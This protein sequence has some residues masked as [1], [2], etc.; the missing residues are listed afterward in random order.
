MEGQD[1]NPMMGAAPEPTPE[2]AQI[3]TPAPEPEPTPSMTFVSGTTTEPVPQDSFAEPATN[4]GASWQPAQATAPGIGSTNMTPGAS[5]PK[6]GNTGIIIAI[7]AAAVI[8][9]GLIVAIIVV[10][11]SNNGGGS[12]NNSSKTGSNSKTSEPEKDKN[13]QRDQRNIQREDDL[14]RMIT[15]VNDY[16]TNNN[17]RTPFGTGVYDKTTITRFVT[18]Y[19]DMDIDQNGVSEGKS[20]V[21][22][23]SSCPQFTDPDGTVYGFTVDLAKSGKT[24]EKIS[25]SG[26]TVDHIFHVYVNASCGSSD[27][28]YTTGT[29]NRQ[30]AIFYFEEGGDIAC[31]DNH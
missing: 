8:L 7:I 5:A 20:F 2:P 15:A 30:I 26:D 3:P 17:G 19:I 1:F 13:Y 14:A 22:S 21:C 11:A 31:N 29:G 9:V 12:G 6:K 23:K 25:Y 16:Q 10:L 18:R 27:G 4:T 28:T 24:N